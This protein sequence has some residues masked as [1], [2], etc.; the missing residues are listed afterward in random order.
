MTVSW[1]YVIS[2]HLADMT[3][4]VDSLAS[5]DASSGGQP[6]STCFLL[7]FCSCTPAVA[8]IL[9]TLTCHLWYMV[10]KQI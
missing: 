5:S 1:E 9:L 8:A 7:T 4:H 10:A 6:Y 2:M 3:C